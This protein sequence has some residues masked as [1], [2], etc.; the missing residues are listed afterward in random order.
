MMTI[1]IPNKNEPN[2]GIMQERLKNIFPEAQIII[3]NDPFGRGKGW[4]IMQGMKEVRGFPL[5]FID[6][7][8]DINP[9]EINRLLPYIRDYDIILGAKGL[10]KSFKRRFITTLS[11]LWV[12]FLFG[13]K[14]DTQTG[15]K[16]F[17]YKPDWTKDGWAFDI[18]ILY[19]ALKA[20]KKIKEVPINA[21]V[22]DS[23]TFKDV[24]QTFKDTINI[25]LFL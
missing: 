23:K 16:L 2:V 20:G 19:K 8:L 17:N 6:G 14:F 9:A 21:T 24:W 10:P 7:D 13:I 18:E 1:I 3:A 5:I 12:W 25:R 4:A 11:K 22:S 15:L